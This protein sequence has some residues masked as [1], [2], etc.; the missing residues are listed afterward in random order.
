MED[1]L[2]KEMNALNRHSSII[3]PQTTGFINST[4]KNHLDLHR[5]HLVSSLVTPSNESGAVIR[6]HAPA[7]R[8]KHGEDSSASTSGHRRIQSNNDNNNNNQGNLSPKKSYST[9]TLKRNNSTEYKTKNISELWANL[10][11]SN[12]NLGR[13][14]HDTSNGEETDIHF[15]NIDKSK[16]SSPKRPENRNNKIE[17][18]IG[19]SNDNDNTLF[20]K[21]NEP[22]I[23][24]H[25]KI[26]HAPVASFQIPELPAGKLLKFNI[27]STWGDPHFLGLMGIEI[28][29]SHGKIVK[30]DDVNS[31]IWANPA[32][33][34]I[35]PEYDN[36]PRTVDNLVDGVNHTCDD[37]HAWLTPYNVGQDHLICIDFDKRVSISMIRIWN[38]NKSRIHSY[39][40]ARYIEITLDNSTI[41]K[42]EIKRAVGSP[43]INEVSNCHECIL[44]TRSSSILS[45]IERN[46]PY[47]QNVINDSKEP[48][49]YRNKKQ[50]TALALAQ[51]YADEDSDDDGLN[52]RNI[53]DKQLKFAFGINM[54]QDEYMSSSAQASLHT[55]RPTTGVGRNRGDKKVAE[56]PTTA[57]LARLSKPIK[58]RVIEICII[59]NW[60]DPDYVGL[61]GLACVNEELQDFTLLPPTISVGLTYDGG[62]TIKKSKYLSNEDTNNVNVL[63]NSTNLTTN[64]SLMW[65]TSTKYLKNNRILILN[66]DLK[67]E[68]LIKG[69]RIWNYNAGHEES[70]IGVKHVNIF[71]DGSLYYRSVVRKAPGESKFD[72]NQLLPLN[73]ISIQ[74]TGYN[75]KETNIL[76]LTEN[77]SDSDYGDNLSFV[78]SKGQPLPINTST[79]C[80]VVQQYETPVNPTGCMFKLLIQSNHGDGYYVGLNGITL[81][82]RYG[83]PITVDKDQLQATPYRDINDLTEVQARGHDARCLEN[84]VLNPNDTYEDSYMWLAPLTRSTEEKNSVFILFDEPVTIS[85]I[86]IWNYSKTPSRGAKEIE[87][88]IDDVLVFKGSLH[89]LPSKNELNSSYGDI[90]WGTADELDLSQSILFTNDHDLVDREYHRIPI[91][92][93]AIEFIDE[94]KLVQ[95]IA[96]AITKEDNAFTRPMTAI[97]RKK[98]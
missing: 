98:H 26:K 41:F 40:G 22:Y 31:Q 91:V 79:I 78:E 33:I 56:R 95:E 96:P 69:L 82:D 67:Y 57:S 30:L 49:S 14:S 15:L 68:R 80:E 10:N 24:R 58:G 87:L 13:I 74:E 76:D 37:L 83:I 51:L 34:N 25:G 85:I 86:K 70:C 17:S 45:A 94:G 32:N 16:K 73:L 89:K 29:D 19:N 84:L 62:V 55:P 36:D 75:A 50:D 5:S 92:E 28:F 8:L 54:T 3:R 93:E 20:T 66:F 72:Y 48:I 47:A 60:G 81:Y 88:Y 71:I 2:A 9:T 59:S 38:Y 90:Q 52:S 6:P 43:S 63:V 53:R 44:F 4:N 12:L 23:T 46:D 61:C 7:P 77:N 39:R 11:R 35:L 97:A 18:T 64:K 42:G 27:L 21:K 65:L 1:A